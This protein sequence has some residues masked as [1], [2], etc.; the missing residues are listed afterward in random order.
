MELDGLVSDAVVFGFACEMQWVRIECQ[1][2]FL[3]SRT[4]R[5]RTSSTQRVS[6]LETAR[7]GERMNGSHGMG[8]S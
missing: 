3:P 2:S 7:E 8:L 5:M 4:L 1:G 6:R